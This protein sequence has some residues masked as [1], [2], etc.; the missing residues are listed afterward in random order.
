MRAE[1]GGGAI[2]TRVALGAGAAAGVGAAGTGA[3]AT[4]AGWGAGAAGTTA[5]GAGGAA[6]AATAGLGAGAA[7][8]AAAGAGAAG[9]AGALAAGAAAG[10]GAAGVGAGAA[11][12]GPR[13]RAAGTPMPGRTGLGATARFFTTSTCTVLDR[14]WLKD[15]R[16]LPASTVLPSSRRPPGRRLSLLLPASCSFW[17][18]IRRFEPDL[19]YAWSRRNIRQPLGFSHFQRA[20][21]RKP[22]RLGPDG[23]RQTARRNRHMNNV[24]TPKN[25]PQFGGRQRHHCRD[26]P[27]REAF[28]LCRAAITGLHQQGNTI[29]ATPFPRRLPARHR[30]PCPACE[31]QQIGNPGTEALLQQRRKTGRNNHRTARCARESPPA[32]AAF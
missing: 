32:D 15:W 29:S 17:S 21:A 19:C 27:A 1:E 11:V 30:L 10:G 18:L 28:T 13:A 3:A 4:G 9:A 24:V 2:A 22:A 23:F 16:T 31:P 14:P 8:G 20:K 6:G 25:T 12:A 5:G 7:T 26:T